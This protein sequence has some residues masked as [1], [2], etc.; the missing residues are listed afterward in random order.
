MTKES[1]GTLDYYLLH[2]D[3]DHNRP[4]GL[5]V[6]EFVLA[7]DLS[8]ARLRSAGWTPADGGWWSSA[9]FARA[10]R[11]DARLRDR[12]AAVDRSAA[13]ALH[14]R[15]GGGPLPDEAA[16]RHRFREDVPLGSGAPLRLKPG[17]VV[18]RVLFA[19]NPD[20][21]RLDRLG[22]VLRMNTRSDRGEPGVR[23]TGRLRVNDTNVRWQLRRVGGDVAWCIDVTAEPADPHSLRWMLRQLVDVARRHGL[24]PATVDRLA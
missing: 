24:V 22:A 12:L 15:L 10:V 14:E 9:A 3:A 17:P 7:D 1:P 5:L 13:A 2:A 21:R 6:E 23:G 18:H 11:T 16:L 8:A 19:G 4:T 20:E